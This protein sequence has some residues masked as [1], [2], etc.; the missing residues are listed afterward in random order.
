MIAA[1]LT[2]VLA[3]S[4]LILP[5]GGTAY[6]KTHE[7]NRHYVDGLYED[8]L[9]AYTEAQVELP[10]APQLFY[11]IGNVLYRQQDFE[12]A[13]EAYTRA[14]L[15]A[16]ADLG[17]DAAYN[18][19]NARFRQQE[20]GAA[21]DAYTRALKGDPSDVD[22]KRNLEL[23]LRALEQQQQQG[24]DDPNNESSDEDKDGQQDPQ[25]Q[26]ADKEQPQQQ[27]QDQDQDGQQQQQSGETQ[28]QEQQDPGS[29]PESSKPADGEMTQEQAER[30]LDSAAEDEKESLRRR[31]RSKGRPSRQREKDW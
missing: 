7:G 6:R 12:G 9:R 8:A 16:P 3:A 29:T 21:R 13:A 26:P 2:V 22:A 4:S 31:M 1:L 18:L 27:D 23:A 30:L 24:Q 25:A 28:P 11:D 15:S 10:E 19:G 17:R 14:L 5:L 20:F